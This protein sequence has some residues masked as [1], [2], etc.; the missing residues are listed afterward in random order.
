MLLTRLPQCRL[1]G[2]D[3]VMFSIYASDPAAPGDYAVELWQDSGMAA[4]FRTRFEGKER[5]RTGTTEPGAAKVMS[6]DAA[7]LL[8]QPPGTDTDVE[9]PHPS[10]IALDPDAPGELAAAGSSRCS[11]S[12]LGSA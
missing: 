12:N 4:E 2:A 7:K 11:V 6:A 5:Q 10:S 3:R 1:S 8:D 9:E